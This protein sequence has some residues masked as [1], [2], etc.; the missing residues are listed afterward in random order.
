MM[1]FEF[2][3]DWTIREIFVHG[4]SGGNTCKALKISVASG[5]VNLI[6]CVDREPDC[7]A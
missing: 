7:F 6:G 3:A 2:R 1:F 4:L 5:R